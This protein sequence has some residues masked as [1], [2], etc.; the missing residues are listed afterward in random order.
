MV[1][2]P[3][4]EAQ[5]TYE[6]ALGRIVLVA[7]G[8]IVVVGASGQLRGLV[9]V[10]RGSAEVVGLALG[11]E[12]SAVMVARDVDAEVAVLPELLQVIDAPVEASIIE[13]APD[14]ERWALWGGGL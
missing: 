3:I 13:V 10:E 6:I 14:V 5:L 2:A 12:V 11:A 4:S 7:Q 8:G 9:E 1:G